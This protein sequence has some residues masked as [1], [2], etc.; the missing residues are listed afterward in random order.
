VEK[1]I[2]SLYSD[3]GRTYDF[4]GL[5]RDTVPDDD[6]NEPGAGYLWDAAI[7]AG[8]T[9][10]NYGEFTRRDPSGRWV[11]TKPSLAPHTSPDCAGWDLEVPDQKRV[12]AWLAEFQRFEAADSLPQLTILRLPN[13]HTAGARAKAPTPRAFMADNDLAL[14]RVI[15]ALSRSRYWTRTVVFVL[16]DDAQDGPDHVDSHRSPLLVISAWNRR[17][18]IHRFANTTDVLATIG[19][20]LH[21]APMSQFDYFGRPLASVFAATPDPRPYAALTP[22]VSLEERNPPDSTRAMMPLDLRREDPPQEDRFN[23]ILWAMIKGPR[24]PYPGTRRLVPDFPGAR[25]SG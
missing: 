16:E 2:P 23:R 15:E 4:E 21:L 20:I 25:R 8:V 3:R 12:D 24:R 1:T 5:N 22:E 11:A 19:G 6:V 13:D 10:R 18:V 9:L 17:G 7:R 14:G